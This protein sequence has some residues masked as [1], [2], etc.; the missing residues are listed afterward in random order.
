MMTIDLKLRMCLPAASLDE[1][2]IALG[3]FDTV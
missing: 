1:I 2:V 3:G